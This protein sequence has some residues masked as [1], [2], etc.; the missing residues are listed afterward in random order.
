VDLALHI[1]VP[2]GGA[3]PDEIIAAARRAGCTSVELT[4]RANVNDAC[5]WQAFGRRLRAGGISVIGTACAPGPTTDAGDV[6]AVLNALL[7]QTASLGAGTLVIAWTWLEGAFGANSPGAPSDVVH[8]ITELLLDL[9]FEAESAG[10]VMAVEAQCRHDPLAAIAIRDLLDE[11]TT[12][13]IMVALDADAAG[14]VSPGPA[15]WIRTLGPRIRRIRLRSG[16]ETLQRPSTESAA[17]LL[18]DA[19]CAA[20]IVV[21]AASLSRGGM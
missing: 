14:L 16:G 4:L 20:M 5:D 11:L 15:T 13:W 3:T 19:G 7:R 18:A 10:V 12:P 6:R 21:D 9:R 17:A 8:K 2:C 1:P